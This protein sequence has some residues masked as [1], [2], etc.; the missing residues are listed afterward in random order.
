MFFSF[1]L[2]SSGFAADA[3]LTGYRLEAGD[4]IKITVEDEPE[5]TFEGQISDQGSIP[6]PLLGEVS[7]AGVTAKSLE[8]KLHKWLQD[9]YVLRPAVAVAV[10]KYP[11]YHVHG[12]VKKSGTFPF[13]PGMSVSKAIAAADGLAPFA[14]RSR[15]TLTRRQHSGWELL[16][17]VGMDDPILPRDILHVPLTTT[18]QEAGEGSEFSYHIGPGDKIKITVENEPNLSVDAKVSAQGGINLPMLGEVRVANLTAKEAEELIRKK[19]IEGFLVD[20]SVFVA[21]AEYRVYY[22]HGEIKKAG[23]YPFQ[24]GL[25]VRKA[26]ALAEGFTEY[27]DKKG[28][29]VV[30]DDDPLFK[31]RPITLND[32]VLPGDVIH[33]TASFW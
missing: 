20:P 1:W 24:P 2:L 8:E 6:F 32:F 15:I 14:D 5:L 19:L 33:V 26:I 3:L 28:I 22:M 4:A 31:E 30:H 12:E 18:P 10:L 7:A 13:Q 27:A 25:T 21:V 11:G 16:T 23:G 9:G 29:L 17:P